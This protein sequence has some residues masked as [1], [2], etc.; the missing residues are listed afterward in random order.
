MAMRLAGRSP[1][2]RGLINANH[3]SARI[4]L[5]G[6]TG[7]PGPG[8]LQMA[9]ARKG[10]G[11]MTTAEAGR[12]GG[13]AVKQKYGSEFYSEIGHKGGQRVKELIEEGKKAEKG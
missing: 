8:C 13:E 7:I 5:G 6:F 10:K 1:M 4:L 12:K 9:K 11:K 2:I 3:A